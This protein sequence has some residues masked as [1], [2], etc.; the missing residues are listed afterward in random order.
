MPYLQMSDYP[1]LVFTTSFTMIRGGYF[2]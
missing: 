1:I 2:M